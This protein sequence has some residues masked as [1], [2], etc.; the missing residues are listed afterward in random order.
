[1]CI[2]G[3]QTNE[4][5]SAVSFSKLTKPFYANLFNK[6]VKALINNAKYYLKYIEKEVDILFYVFAKLSDLS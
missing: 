5:I 6:D 1:M 4:P 2:R 3:Y